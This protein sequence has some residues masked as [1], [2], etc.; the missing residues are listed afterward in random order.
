MAAGIPLVAA[1][2][3]QAAEAPA[4][5]P[6]A[7]EYSVNGGKTWTRGSRMNEPHGVIEVRLVG[8]PDAGC[9][10]KVSL[11][12]YD[13]EGPTWSSSGKQAFLGWAT[14]ALSA[15]SPRA[16]LDVSAHLPKCFGQLDLYR[17]DRKFDGVDNPL[18]NYPEGVIYGDLI[19][20]WNGG[21]SCKPEPTASPT[22]T[23]TATASPT[24][25]ATATPSPTASTTVAPSPTATATVAPSPSATVTGTP[26][27]GPSVTATVAPSPSATAT[28][29]SSAAPTGAGSPSASIVPDGSLAQTG[30]DGSRMLAYGVGGAALLSVGAGVFVAARRRTARR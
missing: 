12:S 13:S 19:S 14:A 28:A 4:C 1:G 25:T 26:S 24:A 18:P 16:S 27:P 2:P 9:V 5:K 6:L 17:G 3:A 21:H 15:D 10:Y 29:T 23:S 20:A 7:V 11:A 22:A 30:G 8:K